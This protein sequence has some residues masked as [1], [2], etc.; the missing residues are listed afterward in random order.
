VSGAKADRALV[1][2]NAGVEFDGFAGCWFR[3]IMCVFG[4]GLRPSWTRASSPWKRPHQEVVAWPAKAAAKVFAYG[5][6]A[7][8][9]ELA[10]DGHAR[11]VACLRKRRARRA[12][13]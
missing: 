5:T 1:L 9:P 12:R 8:Q 13:C 6:C 7:L 11:H 4:T 10:A 3:R 2:G